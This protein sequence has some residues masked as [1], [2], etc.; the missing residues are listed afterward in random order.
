M[1]ETLIERS[2]RI[3]IFGRPYHP[4]FAATDGAIL[5][6]L[7][8]TYMLIHHL[9][10]MSFPGFVA[11][12][13]LMI[14]LYR[15]FLLF[16]VHVLKIPSR[17]FLQDTVLFLLPA[18]AL[19]SLAVGYP[20]R[21]AFDLTGLIFP[22][23]GSLV[24]IGCFLGGCCYG[25]PWKKGVQYPNA[26]FKPVTGFRKFQP[27]ANPG[28]PVIP[29]QLIESA[30]L[31]LIGLGIFAALWNQVIPSGTAMPLFLFGYSVLRFTLDFF[32][33]SSV[34][35]RIGPFSEAQVFSIGVSLV[36][37]AALRILQ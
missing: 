9:G 30:G 6:S 36:S 2:H 8:A 19:V 32:R 17:S 4:Y 10:G 15:A 33:R 20:L 5:V 25:M 34:R 11:V 14:A 23:Y 3:K 31:A 22:I 28:T 24:R 37:I 35:P 16:K 29:T 18:Y 7:S 26:I 13:A 27:G 1:L 21:V 12:F